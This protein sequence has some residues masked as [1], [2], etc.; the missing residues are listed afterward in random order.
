MRSKANLQFVQLIT[1]ENQAGR[2]LGLDDLLLLNALWQERYLSTAEAARLIQK[3]EAE[4]STEYPGFL[5]IKQMDKVMSFDHQLSALPSLY[6]TT[7]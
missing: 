7:G 2:I 3:S 6:T 1:E 4:A 5:D